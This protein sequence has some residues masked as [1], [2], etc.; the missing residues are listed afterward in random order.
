M[1]MV[2]AAKLSVIMGYATVE[3][4]RRISTLM[5]SLGLPTKLEEFSPDAYMNAIIRDKKVRDGGI[6]FVF[7]KG[8]GDFVVERI[9]DLNSLNYEI[10]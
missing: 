1:G 7:N 10:T 9:T 8:I 5:K 6:N 2:Q 3:D 4:L